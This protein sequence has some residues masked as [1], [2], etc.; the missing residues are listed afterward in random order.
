M[1]SIN[2]ATRNAAQ[3]RYHARHRDKLLLEMHEYYQAHKAQHREAAKA[4]RTA[5]PEKHK[6]SIKAA[7]DKTRD[8]IRRKGREYYAA[9]REERLAYRRAYYAA[10]KERAQELARRWNAANH[11]KVMGYVHQRNAKTRGAT[12][13]NLSAA[14][15]SAIKVAYKFR[16][17]YCGRTMNRLTQ[18]HVIP[19]SKGGQHVPENIV[20]AC[21]SCNKRKYNKLAPTNTAAVR[22][23]L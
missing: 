4:W 8:A 3:R 10:H 21:S 16:C 20:P 7:K 18:D 11:D 23:M 1:P 13:A 12:I 22:L 5:N 14:Q 9:H 15:W 2:R 17:A 19:L 6:A